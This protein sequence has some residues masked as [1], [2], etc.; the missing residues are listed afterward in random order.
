MT[1]D[2]ATVPAR[3]GRP[4]LLPGLLVVRLLG[5]IPDVHRVRPWW[6]LMAALRRDALRR[7]GGKVGAGAI[8]HEGVH[9]DRRVTFT[10]GAGSELRDR[11]RLG[12]AEVGDRSGSFVLGEGSVVLSDAQVD[13]TAP[14]TIGRGSHVGRRAQV[15]THAH[16]VSRLAVPVME[17]P[18]TAAPVRIGDDVMI[19]NDVVILPGVS[20][21][22][23]AVV[24]IRAVV[25]RDI[26]PG[27]IAAGVPARVVG[28]RR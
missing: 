6:R 10:L 4:G 8:V 28:R 16:D 5:A 20:I 1:D 27:A 9:F 21:G 14:V 26:A 2:R 22:D 12:I 23:G 18:V 7:A 15:F 11:V 13:C 3:L 25:T 24:A 19:Y 17:A